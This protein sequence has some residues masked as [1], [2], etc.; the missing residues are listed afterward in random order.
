MFAI[1]N[2][3]L[4][5]VITAVN[6]K[7]EGVKSGVPD[8]FLPCPTNTAHGLFVEM[9]SQ[10]GRLSPNQKEWLKSLSANGYQ[11]SVCY[12]FTDAKEVIINYLG[13]KE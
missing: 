9:K 8:L 11:C 4:R 7:Q 5:N 6:L 3:G 10:K 1:P 13:V 12:S 2:G